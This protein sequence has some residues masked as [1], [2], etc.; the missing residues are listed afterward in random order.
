[1]RSM[2]GTKRMA[3]PGKWPN[4]FRDAWE[5]CLHFSKDKKFRMYQD[6]V[7]VPMGSWANTRLSHLSESDQIRRE[8]SVSSGFGRRV[9]NWVGR[10]KAYPTNV[11]HLSTECSNQRHSAVFPV[12]LP[13]WFISLFTETGD[14]VLDP[15]VGSG[16]SAVAAQ[17]LGRHFIGIEL[18]RQY[19]LVAQ[20]R[21][22]ILSPTSIAPHS[23]QVH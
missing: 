10:D 23:I 7:M 14:I 17:D 8:S 15:F 11:L 4:R 13:A 9:A 21:V 12:Q 19:H 22:G 1:M 18:N 16:T 5:R 3:F 20:Q 2:Y 6:A